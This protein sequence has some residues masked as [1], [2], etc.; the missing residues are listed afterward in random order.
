M[1]GSQTMIEEEREAK[2]S[3]KKGFRLPILHLY[4]Q[5][6]PVVPSSPTTASDYEIEKPLHAQPRNHADTHTHTRRET[7]NGRFYDRKPAVLTAHLRI[8]N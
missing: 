2:C 4:T 7:C 5:A 6:S 1:D 3:F 8:R